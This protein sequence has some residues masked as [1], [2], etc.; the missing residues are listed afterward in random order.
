MSSNLNNTDEVDM[1][2]IQEETADLIVELLSIEPSHCAE[3][4]TAMDAVS[5]H[6]FIFYS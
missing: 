4:L 3:Q 2:P 1:C 5:T 6:D